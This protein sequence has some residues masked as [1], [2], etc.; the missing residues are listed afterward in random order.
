VSLAVIPR[1]SIGLTMILLNGIHSIDYTLAYFMPL[2]FSAVILLTRISTDK[3]D[4]SKGV[5]ACVPETKWNL[6][7]LILVNEVVG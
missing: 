1:K 6:L 2:L 4:L 5:V 3:G 7:I